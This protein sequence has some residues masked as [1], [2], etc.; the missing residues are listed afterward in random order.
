MNITLNDIKSALAPHGLIVV[1]KDVIEKL[2]VDF[3]LYEYES[4]EHYRE[5][6]I[7]HN[8]R[9][10]NKVWADEETLNVVATRLEVAFP[11]RKLK[12]LCHGARNGFEQNYLAEKLGADIL[13]TDISDTASNYPRSVQ[14]DFHDENMEW[15]CQHD[16][17]YTN[18]LD[19]SWKPRVACTTWLNQLY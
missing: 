4:Y 2:Q 9:K 12:G 15:L 1:K 18:S 7:L 6:Q 10:I 19:Q 5:V 8:K 11:G 17:I 3:Y 14:W 16:F 13:G